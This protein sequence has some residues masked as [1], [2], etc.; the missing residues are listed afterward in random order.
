[1][2]SPARVIHNLS[3]EQVTYVLF[4]AVGHCCPN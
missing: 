3:D 2:T 4:I 1:M